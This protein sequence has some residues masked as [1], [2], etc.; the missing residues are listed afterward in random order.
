MESFELQLIQDGEWLKLEQTVKQTPAELASARKTVN[1][2]TPP[3][4]PNHID[5]NLNFLSLSL[6]T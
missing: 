3:A 6:F 2:V 4:H 5:L 1:V